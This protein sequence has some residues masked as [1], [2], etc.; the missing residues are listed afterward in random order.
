M[1][2]ATNY[3]GKRSFKLCQA[4]MLTPIQTGIQQLQCGHVTAMHVQQA[5]TILELPGS[6]S[7]LLQQ[8]R[9]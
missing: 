2:S 9:C 1:L 6:I 7:H 8:L 4:L 3:F 5:T